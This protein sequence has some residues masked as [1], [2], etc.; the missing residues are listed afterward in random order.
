[1]I[2]A[3]P[4]SEGAHRPSASPIGPRS[5]YAVA[6]RIKVRSLTVAGLTR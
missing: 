2:D 5:R 4:R 3:C 1:M 6:I